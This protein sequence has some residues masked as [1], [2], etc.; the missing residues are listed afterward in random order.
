MKALQFPWLL[1]FFFFFFFS[2]LI[3]IYLLFF[4]YLFITNNRGFRLSQLLIFLALCFGSCHAQRSSTSQLHE[5]V[6]LK[7]MLRSSSLLII[8]SMIWCPLQLVLLFFHGKR[9]ADLFFKFIHSRTLKRRWLY[10][11][12]LKRSCLCRAS[13]LQPDSLWWKSEQGANGKLMTIWIKSKSRIMTPSTLN[14]LL[15]LWVDPWLRLS[16]F[17]FNSCDLC[18][19]KFLLPASFQLCGHD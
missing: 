1:L 3:S 15:G 6:K 10:S 16:W 12:T 8:L 2:F 9:I 18:F 4:S 17:A 7:V 11:L 19:R 14:C 13:N 5:Q